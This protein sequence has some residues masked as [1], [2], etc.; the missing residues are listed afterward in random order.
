MTQLLLA[1][2]SRLDNLTHMNCKYCKSNIKWI[3]RKPF[4]LDNSAHTFAYCQSV[5]ETT[6]K[7]PSKYQLKAERKKRLFAEAQAKAPVG[8][9]I[10]TDSRNGFSSELPVGKVVGHLKCRT[11]VKFTGP[12]LIEKYEHCS[13]EPSA[14]PEGAAPQI[15]VSEERYIR[16]I[17]NQIS[18]IEWKK[19]SLLN[20]RPSGKVVNPRALPEGYQL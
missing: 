19:K 14:N 9:Y 4:N 16:A 1:N 7:K 15:V 13:D 17:K 5:R 18:A 10:V 11:S 8:S 6:P 20:F 12:L 3:D 2:P